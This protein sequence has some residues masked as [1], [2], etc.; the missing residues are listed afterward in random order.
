MACWKTEGLVSSGTLHTIILLP[1]TAAWLLLL[2][3]ACEAQKGRHCGTGAQGAHGAALWFQEQIALC[4]QNCF[5]RA[6]L[7][8]AKQL[9]L[10]L[11][12][13]SCVPCHPWLCSNRLQAHASPRA[14][15]PGGPT[16]RMAS[17][18]EDF[19]LAA[20]K[21][22]IKGGLRALPGQFAAVARLLTVIVLTVKGSRENWSSHRVIVP[23][24]FAI[25]SWTN[26]KS[27][28]LK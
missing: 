24:V 26:S 9:L 20:R 14:C 12:F 8:T 4:Y 5:K 2:P 18:G 15:N 3:H 16:H 17:H 11:H 21:P 19:S 22:A 13:Y 27:H 1:C 25:S 23:G 6:P 7:N 10:R 28:S